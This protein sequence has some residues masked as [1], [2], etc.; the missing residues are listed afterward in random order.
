[1]DIE[2]D[3]KFAVKLVRGGKYVEQANVGLDDILAVAVHFKN[4]GDY[5]R[6]QDKA[7]NK[8]DF[9]HGS[10]SYCVIRMTENEAPFVR[11]CSHQEMIGI[12]ES[13]PD[14]LTPQGLGLER[15]VRHF[16]SPRGDEDES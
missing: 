10:K 12:L 4:E 3:L 8:V 16:P 1:M 13:L 15:A 9:G 11:V 7:G 2:F 5:M 14:E 6:I